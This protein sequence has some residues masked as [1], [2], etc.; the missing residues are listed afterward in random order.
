[1]RKRT[2]A[3]AGMTSGGAI[4][5]LWAVCVPAKRM[6]SPIKAEQITSLQDNRML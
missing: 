4:F 2:I 5:I 6:S 3:F 1:M